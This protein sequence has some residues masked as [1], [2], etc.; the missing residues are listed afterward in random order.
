M[1]SEAIETKIR[2]ESNFTE[3]QSNT[4]FQISGTYTRYFSD[5]HDQ[6]SSLAAE[7][8]KKALMDANMSIDGIDCIIFA[9]AS[10]DVIE[11]ATANMVQQLL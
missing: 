10:Q 11:P 7:A 4:I 1:S 5:L 8:S 3:F 6:S 2:K 9:S